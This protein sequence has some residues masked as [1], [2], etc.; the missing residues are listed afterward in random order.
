MRQIPVLQPLASGEKKKKDSR[1]KKKNNL[2][3]T[4]NFQYYFIK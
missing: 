1:P 2:Y 3:G 4:E